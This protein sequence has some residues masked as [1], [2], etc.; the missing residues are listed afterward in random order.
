L[1]LILLL[2]KIHGI[3]IFTSICC[4]NSVTFAGIICY[5]SLA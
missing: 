3:L 2:G 1:I 5:I 4:I